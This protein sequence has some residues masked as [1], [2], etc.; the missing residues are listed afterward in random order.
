MARKPASPDT[1]NIAAR[2]SRYLPIEVDLLKPDTAIRFN[3]YLRYGNSFLLYCSKGEAINDNIQAKLLEGGANGLHILKEEEEAFDDYV[4]DNLQLLLQE[5][6]LDTVR[7]SQIV[8]MIS[9]RKIKKLFDRPTCEMIQSSKRVMKGTIGYI[10]GSNR[11][12]M[13][14]MI[15]M[16][17]HDNY[18]YHHSANVGLLGVILAKEI[19]ST[20][21]V[22]LYEAG[23][24]FF[25]H[26]IGKTCIS[27]RILNKPSALSSMEWE[28]VKTHPQKGIEILSA[29]SHLTPQAEVIVLQ[30]HERC[31]GKGYPQGLDSQQIHP[32]GKICNIVDSYDA[33]MA[34]RAYKKSM[35][36][37]QALRIMKDEMSEFFDKKMF[38]KFVR[39]L[40]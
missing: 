6:S 22:D 20:E 8:Y 9:V 34:R 35:T 24:G 19:F 10:V 30:H 2:L 33:L 32:L 1:E 23:Y 17:S 31:H 11:Q 16:L 7:K 29:E 21:D 36:A 15:Q 4:G 39:L 3:L 25:L 18:T 38:E 37:F 27:P 5:P 28:I 14:Q 26:D 12:A 40:H 13:K